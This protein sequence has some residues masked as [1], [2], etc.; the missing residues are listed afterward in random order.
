M[1]TL[2]IKYLIDSNV[3]IKLWRDYTDALDRLKESCNIVILKEILDELARK[4]SRELN[5]NR[6][7]SERFIKLL[8][9]MVENKA[10]NIEGFCETFEIKEIANNKYYYKGNKISHNDLLLII[11]CYEEE[12]Y[13]LVTSDKRLINCS[14][15]ILKED[16][17]MT[18]DE[19]LEE[20]INY[21]G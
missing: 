12:N 1:I 11:A 4:E 3:I 17:V 8:P 15:D 9:Y 10:N 7:L 13:V 5:G 6:Y 20:K 2:T 21:E 16:K 14:K 19:F 18:I